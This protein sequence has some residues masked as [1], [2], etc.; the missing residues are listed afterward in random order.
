MKHLLHITR[1]LAEMFPQ[2]HTHSD[3]FKRLR[4]STTQ[5]SVLIVAKWYG[6]YATVWHHCLKPIENVVDINRK[7]SD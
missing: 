6:I 7:Q 1:N 3:I 4:W 2:Y 5:Q